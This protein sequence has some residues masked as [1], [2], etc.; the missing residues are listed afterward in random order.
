MSRLLCSSR[1]VAA[2]LTLTL[3]L[4][5]CPREAAAQSPT[6]VKS[7][8]L[9]A[10]ARLAEWPSLAPGSA[11]VG[12]VVGDDG[13]AAEFRRM[14]EGKSIGGHALEVSRPSS[15]DAWSGCHLLFVSGAEVR[16]FTPAL[17]NLRTSPVLT[18]SDGENFGR[19]HGVIEFVR[20]GSKMDLSIN[21]DAGTRKRL[22]LSSRLLERATIVKDI[23]AR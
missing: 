13:V 17:N 3:A 2:G 18:I 8:L 10:I 5:A 12:C 19:A 6:E 9:I 11:M 1:G 23:D 16:R 22:R 14:A 21:V 20:N 15:P 7:A 4:L